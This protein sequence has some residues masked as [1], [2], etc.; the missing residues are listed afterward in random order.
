VTAGQFVDLMKALR[1]VAEIAASR[2][3]GAHF[4]RKMIDVFRVPR[5]VFD[6]LTAR[7]CYPK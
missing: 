6:M 7:A 4:G 2:F 5:V 1:A 3:A